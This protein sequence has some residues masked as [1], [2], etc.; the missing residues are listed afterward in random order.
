MI[1]ILFRE[2]AT[3]DCGGFI[4]FTVHPDWEIHFSPLQEMWL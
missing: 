3:A 1:S 4:I 2:E